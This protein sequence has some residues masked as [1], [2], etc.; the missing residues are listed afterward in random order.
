MIRSST[1]RHSSKHRVKQGQL[2]YRQMLRL[3]AAK[4][5]VLGSKLLNAQVGNLS[6]VGIAS[7]HS[8][9]VAGSAIQLTPDEL[10]KNFASL[11][12]PVDLTR[13]TG[14]LPAP[15]PMFLTGDGRLL[16]A[17][18]GVASGMDK[19]QA[20]MDKISKVLGI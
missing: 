13:T 15:S 9:I 4:Q 1:L 17:G 8:R 3:N 6:G 2:A 12:S 7:P 10:D 18:G 16:S 14:V 20:Q 19:L 11:A 5:K